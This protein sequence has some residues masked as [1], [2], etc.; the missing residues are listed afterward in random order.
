MSATLSQ[1]VV[2]NVPALFFRGDLSPDGN[3]TW[4]PTLAR[5]LANM[6]SVVFPTL[7]TDLLAN[8]PACLSALRRQFLEDP[9]A[10][11]DTNGCEQ[12][13]PKIQFVAPAK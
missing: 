13:S 10:K 2:S 11:L 9:A 8:G 5:G 4:I 1:P 6:Q 7:G 3:P 12:K